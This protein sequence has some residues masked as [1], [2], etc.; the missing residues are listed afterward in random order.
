MNVAGEVIHDE[1]TAD[2]NATI[3]ERIAIDIG[4]WYRA[5]GLV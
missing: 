3:E 4:Q 5:N 1:A 2:T